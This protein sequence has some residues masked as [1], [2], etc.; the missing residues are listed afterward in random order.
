MAEAGVPET[1]TEHPVLTGI[2][3]DHLL[4]ETEIERVVGSNRFRFNPYKRTEDWFPSW[5]EALERA[6]KVDIPEDVLEPSVLLLNQ[7][8]HWKADELGDLGEDDLLETY[9]EMVCTPS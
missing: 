4:N 8:A 9:E 2:R 1:R 7:G 3:H 5:F 6:A